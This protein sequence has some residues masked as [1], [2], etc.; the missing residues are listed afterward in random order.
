MAEECGL[1]G[2]YVVPALHGIVRSRFMYSSGARI[3]FAP[4]MIYED[5]ALN[6]CAP[7]ERPSDRLDHGDHAEFP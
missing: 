2:L 3:H 1:K 6:H 5:A 4:S 7:A